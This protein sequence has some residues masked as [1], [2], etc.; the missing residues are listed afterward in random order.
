MIKEILS[1]ALNGKSY[2]RPLTLIE[3]SANPKNAA[4]RPMGR[5]AFVTIWTEGLH[6]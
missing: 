1:K 3:F 6:V 5:S 2:S 4:K